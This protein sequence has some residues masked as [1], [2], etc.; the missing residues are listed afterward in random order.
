MTHI[1]GDF[2]LPILPTDDPLLPSPNSTDET[3]EEEKKNESPEEL[4]LKEKEDK[5]DTPGMILP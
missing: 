2:K 3:P 1:E 4:Q 5:K